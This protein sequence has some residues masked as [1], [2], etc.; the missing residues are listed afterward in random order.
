LAKSKEFKD[1]FNKDVPQTIKGVVDQDGYLRSKISE[2]I[3]A[4]KK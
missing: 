3:N 2:I 4:K 1:L